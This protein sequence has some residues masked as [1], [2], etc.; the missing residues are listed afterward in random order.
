MNEPDGMSMQSLGIGDALPESLWSAGELIGTGEE[1]SAD[2]RGRLVT[3]GFIKAAV[4]RRSRFLLACVVVGLIAGAGLYFS[5]PPAYSAEVTLLLDDSAA[6]SSAQIQTDAALAQ[7]TA[8]GEAVISQLN[9]GQ[10]VPEFLGSYVVTTPSAQVLVITLSAPTS[11]EA[12]QRAQAVATQF[13]AVRAQYANAQQQQLEQGLNAQLALSKKNLTTITN[14]VNQLQQEPSSP[15][16]KAQLATAQAQ[17]QTASNNY[18][19]TQQNVIGT[20]LTSR[21]ATQAEIKDSRVIN[22]ATPLHHSTFKTLLLYIGGGAFGG[23][24]VGLAIIAIGALTSDRLRRRDDVAYAIGSPVRLSVGPLRESRVRLPGLQ[25]KV[26]DRDMRSVVDY[27][28]T[29]TSLLG[30]GGVGSLAVVAVDDVGTVARTVV[31]LA[32]SN[33]KE[34]KRVLLADLSQGRHAARLLG[35]PAP[36]V[37]RITSQGAHLVL[38]VPDADEVTP[39]GPFRARGGAAVRNAATDKA[40][41][42]AGLSAD[43]V[44]SLVTLDPRGVSDHLRTWASDAVAVVTA[45]ESTAERVHSI[46]EMVRQGGAHLGSTVLLGADPHDESLGVVTDVY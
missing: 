36:G 25:P 14:E 7:S 30:N 19:Q 8:V 21:V 3:L 40:L 4:K 1:A 22:A 10:G 11:G 12:V 18:G 17:E 6:N 24:V 39:I 44:L 35:E 5:K 37:Q 28:R 46:G 43:L 9:L 33:A 20:V 38:A 26:K 45:G 34:G 29:V 27:L 31:S 15:Q 16:Q 41:V 2:P 42:D 13:L 32:L 23:L